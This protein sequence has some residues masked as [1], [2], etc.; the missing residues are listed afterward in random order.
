MFAWYSVDLSSN[1]VEVKKGYF[2]QNSF[3]VNEIKKIQYLF[4]AYPE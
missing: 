3:G 4:Y 1:L 2:V